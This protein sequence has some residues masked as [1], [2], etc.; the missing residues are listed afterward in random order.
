V[1]AQRVLN[2]GVVRDWE[3]LLVDLGK[4]SLVDQLFHR[5]QVGIAKSDVWLNRLQHGQGCVVDSQEHGIVDL[6]QSEQLKD[7]SGLGVKSID[8]SNSD[9]N[10]KLVVWLNV[11]IAGSLGLSLE[12]DQR[13]LLSSV[14]VNVLLCSLE[15]C[16]SLD[17]EFLLFVSL[18]LGSESKDFFGRLS[19]LQDGLW[20][21]RISISSKR[22]I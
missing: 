1:L 5:F 11:I 2:D 18:G 20:N 6:S 9:H 16:L 3:S 4:A 15:D 19:L 22:A 10:S 12:S 7:L 8:T 14:F 13:S 17:L 21:W